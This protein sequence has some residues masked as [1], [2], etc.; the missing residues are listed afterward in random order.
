L[1]ANDFFVKEL[2]LFTDGSVNTQSKIGFGA[3][4]LVKTPLESIESYKNQVREKR[5]EN[6]SSTKLELE[7]LLWALSELGSFEGKI[8]VYTDSQNIISLQK[9]RNKLEKN[10]YLSSKNKL[11][12]NSTL[13]QEFY[14]LTDHLNCKFEKVQGHQP[15]KLKTKI[16]LLFTLVD[17]K[18]RKAVRADKISEK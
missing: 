18:V 14:K 10:N 8:T 9:R 1:G 2:L 7:T 5:F 4:L 12:G 17:K 3:F 11:L 6:T 13:Y 15:S 16:D